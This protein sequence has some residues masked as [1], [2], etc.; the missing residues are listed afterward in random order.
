MDDKG[1][2]NQMRWFGWSR[3]N[4]EWNIKEQT[5]KSFGDPHEQYI[6][7]IWET[8]IEWGSMKDKLSFGLMDQYLIVKR[9]HEWSIQIKKF[10]QIIY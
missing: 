3:R 10:N 9:E 7:K 5:I 4:D 1:V 8:T 6:L 2:W